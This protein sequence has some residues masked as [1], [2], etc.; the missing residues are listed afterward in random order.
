MEN[1]KMENTMKDI[2]SYIESRVANIIHDDHIWKEY[3]ESIIN[4]LKSEV[5]STKDIIKDYA[6]ESLTVN[7]IEM[8]GYLRGLITMIDRFDGWKP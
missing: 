7:R 6:E 1:L 8:E 3:Y 5:E 2:A 4:E